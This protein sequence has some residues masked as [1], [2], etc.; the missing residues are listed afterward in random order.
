MSVNRRSSLA[1]IRRLSRPRAEPE[2][3]GLC[4][5]EL[6]HDHAHLF[7]T[8][9]RRLI[10]ACGACT[11]LFDNPAAARFHPVPK[12]VEFLPDFVLDDVQWQALQL[13]VNLA[14]FVLSRKGEQVIALYPSPAGVTEASPPP[15]AWLALVE[16]NPALR[17]LRPDVE[18]LLVNRLGPVP[19]HY[20]VG[21]DKCYAL[22][23]L[24]RAHW[25]GFSGGTVVRAKI[26]EFFADL[27]EQARAK[28]PG[29]DAR[30]RF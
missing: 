5:A 1:A 17:K 6:R 9:S 2:R 22:A 25:Q 26:E 27:Q 12:N 15:E 11:I 3:C 24:V 20:Y 16:D 8:S 28:G 23:G 18:A 13:P 30:S 21:V 10:C 29:I 19:E 14:F 7:E 4:G